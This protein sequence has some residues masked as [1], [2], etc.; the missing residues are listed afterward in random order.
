M[1]SKVISNFKGS[2]KILRGIFMGRNICN[3]KK[4]RLFQN[5]II[6]S[7]QIVCFNNISRNTKMFWLKMSLNICN[8]IISNSFYN[9]PYSV[10]LFEHKCIAYAIMQVL[11]HNLLWFQWNFSMYSMVYNV[12]AVCWKFSLFFWKL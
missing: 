6:S 1:Y 10:G 2:K 9:P 8:N 12:R 4:N 5:P 11:P 7:M 3:V